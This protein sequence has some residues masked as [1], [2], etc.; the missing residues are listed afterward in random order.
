MT[1]NRGLQD[2]RPVKDKECFVSKVAVT[3][4]THKKRWRGWLPYCTVQIVIPSIQSVQNVIGY[5]C[6]R[7]NGPTVPTNGSHRRPRRCHG[8][9]WRLEEQSKTR[10]SMT[11]VCQGDDSF[12][13]KIV[14]SPRGRIVVPSM[15]I[16]NQLHTT[17]NTINPVITHYT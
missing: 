4:T 17:E 5:S 1:F 9:G 15:H 16:I 8:V 2:K 13:H 7:G 10:Q 12:K 14:R 6:S 3:V 11:D